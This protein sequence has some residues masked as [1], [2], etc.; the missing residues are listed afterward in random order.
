MPRPASFSTCEI[1]SVNCLPN[2]VSDLFTHLDHPSHD[3][4]RQRKPSAHSRGHGLK[5]CS[6]RP[7]PPSLLRLRKARVGS[8]PYDMQP[9]RMTPDEKRLVRNMHFDQRMPPT[10][11]AETVGRNLSSVCRLLAQKKAPKPVGRP[12]V[13]TEAKINK[14]IEVLEDMVARWPPVM[15]HRTL[16]FLPSEFILRHVQSDSLLRNFVIWQAA[17]SVFSSSGTFAPCVEPGIAFLRCRSALLH[18]LRLG[19]IGQQGFLSGY[20]CFH[21]QELRVAEHRGLPR[22]RRRR[23]IMRSPS[24]WSCAVAVGRCVSGQWRTRSMSAAIGFGSCATR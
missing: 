10:E 6:S 18:R 1:I 21:V 7:R 15:F 14:T 8:T 11:I 19:G 3:S 23:P 24:P 9:P 16:C 13:F 17:C 5:L 20:Q 12:S 4:A 2:H 22:L